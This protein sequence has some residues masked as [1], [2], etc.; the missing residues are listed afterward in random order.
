M[1]FAD[2]NLFYID[3]GSVFVIHEKSQTILKEIKVFFIL[4]FLIF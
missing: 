4:F 3:K 1:Q 2:R